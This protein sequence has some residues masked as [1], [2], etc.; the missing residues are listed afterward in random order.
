MSKEE[1]GQ[2]DGI[3][4]YSTI[5]WYRELGRHSQS[6]VTAIGHGIAWAS[7]S[8]TRSCTF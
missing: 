5:E 3:S 8:K 2:Y 6:P 1:K 4:S 7:Q